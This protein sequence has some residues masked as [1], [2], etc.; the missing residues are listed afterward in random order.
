[1]P[2][3]DLNSDIG[4]SFGA[5]RMGD[6]GAMV[7]VVSS[8]NVACGFHAG[9]PRGIL[10]TVK[11]AVAH[12]VAIGA[13]VGY[14]DLAGFGR[15]DMDVAS[16]D[17][18]PETIYQIGALQGLAAAAGGRVTY[19]KPHGALYNFVIHDERQAGDLVAAIKQVDPSLA[20]LTLPGSVAGQLAE[21]AGLRVA[22]EAFADRGYTPEGTLLSRKLPGAVINDPD[23]V[24]ERVLRL[25]T[26]GEIEAVDGSTVKLD[27]D[28]VCVHGDT[29]GAV[30]LAKAV[31]ARLEAAGVEIAGF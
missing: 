3:I 11:A 1:M 13:H 20:L 27:A 22:R 8:A 30:A 18:I 14:R 19:V 23:A 28:S 29:P 26:S 17:L 5:W 4:E 9:D 6:D 10:A 25:V 15:R 7:E 12:G 31:R 24:A 21:A 16:A 2:S